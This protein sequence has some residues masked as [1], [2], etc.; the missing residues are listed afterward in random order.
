MGRLLE[1]ADSALVVV[2][3]QPG[4]YGSDPAD[5]FLDAVLDRV[6][7]LAAVATALGVPTVVTEEDPARNGPTAGAIIDALRPGT[8]RLAK[9]VFGLADDPAILAAVEATGRRTAVLVGLESDVCVAHSG[10]GL[11]DRGYRV[12][13]VS[14][15]TFAPGAMHDHGLRRMAESGA[16]V[17]HAKGVYYEWVRT[18][19]AA[20]AFE[21]DHPGLA[22]PPGFDL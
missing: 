17:V 18:L 3:A 22:D 9:P 7:W 8:P 21:R 10:L 15:G 12:A 19:E 2:D 13:V 4:F 14:D 20:R 16:V 1:V 5:P 6:A 11:L